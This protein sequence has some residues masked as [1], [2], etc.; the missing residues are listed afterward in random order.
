MLQ[1]AAFSFILPSSLFLLILIY[2]VIFNRHATRGSNLKLPPGPKRLPVIGNLHHMIG[3]LAHQRLYQLAKMYGPVFYLQLGELPFVTITTPEA[4]KEVLMTQELAFSDHPA[5]PPSQL[6]SYENSSIFFTPYGEFWRQ[7]RKICVLGLLGFE[8]V[9]SFKSIRE[10]EVSNLI[11]YIESLSGLP[12]NL[13]D[14]I[15]ACMNRVF[16]KAS[17]GETCKQQDEFIAL[18]HEGLR[19]A[20]RLD[21]AELFPSLKFLRYLS[22]AKFKL[23]KIKRK[24][25]KILNTI[26]ADHKMRRENL[27]GQAGTLDKEDIVDSYCVFRNL[28]TADSI[29]Q[30]TTLK[31]MISAGTTAPAI[32]V[33]WAMSELLKNPRVMAQAQNEIRRVLKGKDRIQESDIEELN[34]LKCIIKET[35][36]M[37]PPA[38]VIPRAPREGCK[39]NGCDIPMNSTVLIHVYALGRDPRYWTNPEKFEPERFIESSVDYKGLYFQLL[40]FGSGRRMCPGIAFAT[41]SV[42]LMLASLLYHFDWKLANGQAPEQLDMTEVYGVAARRKDELYVIASPCTSNSA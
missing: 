40:P 33:E 28:T 3:D 32:T 39:V 42:E 16:S 34:Y 26:L 31:D 36:R 19:L 35:L 4:A 2:K 11:G 13:S 23:N 29:L 8:S 18:L 1:F 25:D 20:G 6:T 21:I 9:R 7:L 15:T 38:P 24:Y 41:A 5:Y 12:L 22:G 30:P 17:F 10:N 37:H 27:G 14:R